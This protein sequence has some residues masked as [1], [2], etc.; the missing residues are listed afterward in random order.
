MMM[1]IIIVMVEATPRDMNERS[2]G[3][4]H[5]LVR[6]GAS[7]KAGVQ[8]PQLRWKRGKI[9]CDAGNNDMSRRREKSTI[10]LLFP[11]SS[12][13]P[14]P[15]MKSYK[16]HFNRAIL[17][18]KW[19][20]KYNAAHAKYEIFTLVLHFCDFYYSFKILWKQVSLHSTSMI[21]LINSVLLRGRN[22]HF[23]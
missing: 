17:K 9:R 5:E 16:I 1:M 7:K 19:W 11:R 13:S 4:S 22:I 15:L 12:L 21:L 2:F 20:V 3:A 18:M 23:T 6:R 10:Q 14:P 8:D